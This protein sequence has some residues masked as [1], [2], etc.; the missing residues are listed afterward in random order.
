MPRLSTPFSEKLGLRLPLIAAPMAGGP[1]SPELVAAC[2]AAGALG[3]FGFAYTQPEEMKK[4]AAM[5]RAKTDKPIGINLFV[6]PQPATVPPEAQRGVLDAVA[7]YFKELGLPAPEPVKPPYAPDLEAQIEAVLEIKPRVFTVH[8]GCLSQIE[9]FKER[10]ILLGGSATCAEE[11]KRLEQAGYDF[12]VAQGGEAG[13]HRGTY[14]RDPYQALTGTLA[15]TR[16]VVR[17]VK[18]PVVAAGGIMDGEGIAAAL[19]LGA[20]AA[21][22]GTAF[23]ACPEG[24]AAQVYKDAVL[25]AK[26]DDTL[27]TEK[28]SGKPA[29]GLRNRFMQEMQAAPQ[30]A[31]PAQNS[32]MGKLRQASAKAGRPD[33]VAM[34]SGQGAPLSRALPAAELIDK[35]EA[36]TVAAIRNLKGVLHE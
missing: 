25:H 34:W 2:S 9:K 10:K 11:A 24:G 12:V 4:Q 17:A 21:Q 14:L 36:E 31:F 33:F 3:S 32:L 19:A 8:L 22:L 26:E 29:R 16:I 7:G 30:I 1:T 23:I 35:L 6:A 15:L 13:G 18:L 5:V 20:Q 28:F 27:V